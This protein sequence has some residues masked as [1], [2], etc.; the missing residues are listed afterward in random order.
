MGLYDRLEIEAA[1]SCRDLRVIERPSTG[2]PSRSILHASARL[3]SRPTPPQGS[4]ASRVDPRGVSRQGPRPWVRILGCL[5]ASRRHRAA[6]G[7]AP[8]G[9]RGVV[10]RPPPARDVHVPWL[11]PRSP[12]LLRGP[13][14]ERRS[15]R[16]RPSRYVHARN[17][18]ETEQQG[19]L[20]RCS[21]QWSRQAEHQRAP[22]ARR[23]GWS[24]SLRRSS[25]ANPCRVGRSNNA[26][27]VPIKTVKLP[28]TCSEDL[29]WSSIETNRIRNRPRERAPREG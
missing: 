2:R 12:V 28:E 18:G 29:F 8:H 16:D 13:F 1:S 6:P 27:V 22:S 5:G 24:P 9:R 23:R 3:G 19:P 7:L 10:G 4:L 26:L 20:T 15:G 17:R 11:D 21:V 25:R 14:H